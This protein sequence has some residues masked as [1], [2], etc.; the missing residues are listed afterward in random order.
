[1]V[2]PWDPAWSSRACELAVDLG[3]RLARWLDGRIEH[4]GSTSVPGLS[5]KPVIDLLAPAKSLAASA[6][7]DGALT[8]AGWH[9]VPPELDLRPWRRMYVLPEGDRRIAHLH[10]VER[11]H[12]RWRDTVR[13]R[14]ELRRRPDLADA[15]SRLKL[16]AAKAHRQDREAYTEAKSA[17]IDEVLRGP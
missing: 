5:A 10:L 11:Q 6:E 12:P 2:V 9:L 4:V 8:E 16:R 7:A 17:F 15:Y 3:P 14:D 1:V 13:F